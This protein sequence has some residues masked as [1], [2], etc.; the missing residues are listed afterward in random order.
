MRVARMRLAKAYLAGTG[1]TSALLSAAVLSFLT[2]AGLFGVN[3]LPGGSSRAESD[4]VMVAPGAGAPEAAAAAAAGAPGA[5]AAAPAGGAVGGAGGAAAGGVAGGPAG[6]P[7]G[8]APDGGAGPDAGA[9]T[10]PAPAGGTGLPGQAPAPVAPAQDP[11]SDTVSE[12]EGTAEGA[13]GV[14]LPLS[15]TTQPLTDQLDQTI[16]DAGN[17]VGGLLNGNN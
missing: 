15:E 11:V 6:A 4:T 8:T 2:L 1:A 12:V 13:T 16:Q 17:T 10:A 14:N 7:G 3:G 5:I 9:T